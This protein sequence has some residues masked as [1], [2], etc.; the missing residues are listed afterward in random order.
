MEC[1]T[2]LSRAEKSK[3]INHMAIPLIINSVA[4]LLIGLV[5]QAMV[6][7]ISIVAFSAVGLISTTLYSITGILGMFA[8]AFNILGSN[9]KGN[10][11]KFDFLNKFKLSLLISSVIGILFYILFL[12]F[13]TEIL[14]FLFGINGELL[15]ESIKYLNIYSITL[16]INLLLFCFSSYFKIINKTKWILYGSITAG[17]INIILDYVLIFGNF[18]FPKLGIAGAAIAS[19]IALLTNLLI[20]IFVFEEKYIFKMKI[21]DFYKNIRELVV[22]SVP[23]MGQEF[24]EGTVFIISINA[25]VARVGEMELSTFTLLFNIVNIVLMPM[26]GYSSASLTLVSQSNGVQKEQKDIPRICLYKSLCIYLILVIIFVIC[27]NYIPKIMTNDANLI[28]ISSLYLPIALFA[29][30]F[31]YPHSIYKYSLQGIRQE[32]WVLITS[33]IINLLSIIIICIFTYIFKMGLVGIYFGIGTNYLLLSILFYN[34]YK[35]ITN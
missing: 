30:F 15:N 4:G 35:K 3:Q 27:K 32:D 31:N 24:I 17:F 7:R 20:Y 2:L 22:L 18:G 29:Q 12:F 1:R 14:V 5:D 25:I 11:N 21:I 28:L 13:Q 34:K 16:G 23:L 9:S 10:D 6:G 8:I 26:Y 19:V 33:I